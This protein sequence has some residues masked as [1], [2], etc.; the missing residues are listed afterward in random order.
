MQ[1]LQGSFIIARPELLE[2]FLGH[3][4]FRSMVLDRCWSCLEQGLL[5]IKDKVFNIL[6]PKLLISLKVRIFG[7]TPTTSNRAN[8]ILMTIRFR[9]RL[10]EGSLAFISNIFS[11]FTLPLL[12]LFHAFELSPQL[13]IFLQLFFQL[14]F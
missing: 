11:I 3:I 5:I 14:L 7:C 1:W 9:W 10:D 12:L 8:I 4:V 6:I 2:S 13:V